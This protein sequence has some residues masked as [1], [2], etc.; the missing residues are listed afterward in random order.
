MFPLLTHQQRSLERKL[1]FQFVLLQLPCRR[2]PILM[3]KLPQLKVSFV[4][5]LAIQQ[6][7]GCAVQRIIITNYFT[8]AEK[9]GICM[10]LSSWSTSTIEDVSAASSSGLK[11]FQLYVYKDRNV[12]L[13]LIRKAERAGFKAIAVTVDTP[14]LG[15]RNDDVRNRFALPPHLTLANYPQSYA[16]GVKSD[17]DSGLAKFVASLID[18][19]LTWSLIPWLR[20]VTNLKIVLKGILTAED[21]RLAVQYGADGILV[22]NHGARQ[23]DT[24]P[25]TVS[26]Q[27]SV[28]L[29]CVVLSIYLKNRQ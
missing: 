27:G 26:I 6:D 13:D 29:H 24:V 21:A 20:S 4:L 23:L 17:A 15:R 11:W 8:A 18:S 9:A 19:S 16:T 22:S 28:N 5:Q 3:E 7:V 1:I 25:A 2:W 14:Y 10:T 12:T